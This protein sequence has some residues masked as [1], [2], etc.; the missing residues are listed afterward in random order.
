MKLSDCLINILIENQITHIFELCGGAITHILDSLYENQEISVVSMHHEM[1]AA[2]AAE[3]YARASE[4]IGVAM[5]TSGPGATNLITGIGSCFFDSIPCLFLTGQVNTYEYKHDL[6]IRQLGFQETNIVDIVKP[7]TKKAYMVTD[8]DTF[9]Q[10]LVDMISV[11]RTPRTGPVLLDIPMNIQRSSIECRNIIPHPDLSDHIF[12]GENNPPVQ[13]I[14]Q[15][16]EKSTRPVVIAGGGLRLG[17]ATA[18]LFEF[19]RKTKIPVVST[20]MGLDSFPH[21][22]PCYIGMLGTYGNRYA[23]LAVANSDLLLI[24]GSRL[25]TRQTGTNPGSFARE[26]IKIHVDAD[27]DELNCKVMVDFPVNQN[28]KEFLKSVNSE[29]I[30][31]DERTIVKWMDILKNYQKKYPSYSDRDTFS[32]NPNNIMHIISEKSPDDSIYCVD[33]GQIQMWAAQSID[34]RGR[35]R[36]LTEGGMASIGSALP[37]AIGAA[38]AC[39]DKTIVCIVGDGGFQL[40]IQEL[41]TIVHHNLNIKIILFNN[42]GYGMIKQFQRQNFDGRYQSTGIGYSNPDFLQVVTA[43]KIMASRCDNYYDLISHL[44]KHFSDTGPSFLEVLISPV[45]SVTPKLSVNKPIEEQEPR[46]DYQEQLENMLIP[47]FDGGINESS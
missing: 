38:C 28:V 30:S 18:E 12:S 47:P 41:Q 40:N 16:I 29:D 8:P 39:P 7:I 21:D 10:T 46:L 44:E 43:Y 19:I 2:I 6:P 14:I 26:A 13:Q 45:S 5:A 34:L 37:L 23:N 11:A 35:Q 31:L 20:L 27:S 1:A 25:D 9:V 42:N 24:L 22:N 3:G 33:V 15:A 32:D 36:F 17:K 4:N